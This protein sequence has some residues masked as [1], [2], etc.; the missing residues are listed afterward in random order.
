M[1]HKKK[2]MHKSVIPHMIVDY[3]GIGRT[4]SPDYRDSRSSKNPY[5]TSVI[6]DLG[7][8]AAVSLSV[9]PLCGAKKMYITRYWLTPCSRSSLAYIYECGTEMETNC[10]PSQTR[11]R[12]ARVCYSR[13]IVNELANNREDT[14]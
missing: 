10:T 11:S 7:A 8:S 1:T 2:Y 5:K 12:I 9:C 14:I 4:V 13:C 3:N 6:V